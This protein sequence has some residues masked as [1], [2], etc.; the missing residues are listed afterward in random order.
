M[1]CK[2][3]GVTVI[4]IVH[5]IKEKNKQEMGERSIWGILRIATVES[6]GREKIDKIDQEEDHYPIAES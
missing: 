3:R 2:V 6:K 1:R 4:S 5:E